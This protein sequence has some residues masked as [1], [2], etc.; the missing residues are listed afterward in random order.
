[1]SKRKKIIPALLLGCLILSG[2]A[3]NV[4]ADEV[5]SKA[6]IKPPIETYYETYVTSKTGY[7]GY[8]TKLVTGSDAVC[9]NQ[10][11]TNATSHTAQLF[12]SEGKYRSAPAT[13][14]EGSR[15]TL[16]V[17][18]TEGGVYAAKGSKYRQKHVVSKLGVIARGTYSVDNKDTVNNYSID[19]IYSEDALFDENI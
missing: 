2:S 3:I 8:I 4:R 18:T 17:S 19:H 1:M 11:I 14:S 5:D 16:D 13:I 12:N 7:T 9:N 6:I 10:Y 15:K